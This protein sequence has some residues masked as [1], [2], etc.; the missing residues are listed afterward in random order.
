MIKLSK[1]KKNKKYINNIIVYFFY[2]TIYKALAISVPLT[3]L[4][5][6]NYFKFIPKK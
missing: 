3:L 1:E 2:L 6:S 5:I 4:H